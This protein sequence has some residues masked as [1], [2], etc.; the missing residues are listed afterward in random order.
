[1][2][3]CHRYRPATVR[4]VISDD[5]ARDQRRFA[6]QPAVLA[7]LAFAIA[8]LARAPLDSA[9]LA[10]MPVEGAQPGVMTSRAGRRHR[11][12]WLRQNGSVVLLLLDRDS[13]ATRRAREL[14]V[15]IDETRAAV[16]APQ[17]IET[18]FTRPIEDW[19]V[20]L[21]PEQRSVVDQRFAGPALL[22][23]GPGTGK[24]VVGVHR[25]A[26]LAAEGRKVLFTTSGSLP[27][28]AETMYRTLVPLTAT[29]VWFA[30]P[31][32]YALS[33]ISRALLRLDPQRIDAAFDDAWDRLSR[34]RS[35]L[36]RHGLGR[37]YCRDEIAWVIKGRGL[38]TRDSDLYV[39]S[40]AR[41]AIWSLF[42][43]YE[44]RLRARR[45]LD[46]ADAMRIARDHVRA[47][48]DPHRHDAVIVDDAHN[49]TRVGL[50]LVAGI[51]ADRED[52]LLLIGDEQQSLH[53][54]GHYLEKVGL[55]L[56]GR[57]VALRRDHRHTREIVAFANRIESG[58]SAQVDT[59]R[60]GEVPL[61][62]CFDSLDEHDAALDAAVR[63]LAEQPGTQPG[64]IGLLVPNAEVLE[65]YA[66]RH[67]RVE[68][69][70]VA[71]F[72]RAAGLEFKHV[73]I[74]RAD[75]DTLHDA[76]VTG[77][78]V[79]THAQ[80]LDRTRRELFVAVTRAR[81]SLWIGSAGV[82]SAL[83]MRCR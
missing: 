60:S 10:T 1:L 16:V 70:E 80:R 42:V 37:Q 50:E 41:E 64:D 32:A 39:D 52:G 82:P 74:P 31:E 29:H 14:D 21:H 61:L 75:A 23:G 45:T 67:A 79:D 83:V 68:G 9:L 81:D 33:V 59:R 4:L 49:L 76:P 5:F 73:L 71:T 56:R 72:G 28:A 11:I 62:G 63:R 35:P 55:D 34:R 19:L 58:L 30:R 26:R 3:R 24:T 17:D 43:T 78:G 48:G 36:R 8:E 18:V 12:G 77:E 66:G 54:D 27:A 22:T 47:H 69:V 2:A 13:E 38:T 15:R 6:D 46:F 57:T 51:A 65:Q 20:L 40:P 53:T 7:D 44:R 25:A